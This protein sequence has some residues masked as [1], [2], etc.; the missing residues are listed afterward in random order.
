M[1]YFKINPNEV[2]LSTMRVSKCKKCGT[3]TA[4]CKA[5]ED[6]KWLSIDIDHSEMKFID[7][8]EVFEVSGMMLAHY[9]YCFPNGFRYKQDDEIIANIFNSGE[10][11]YRIIG[12]DKEAC[13]YYIKR[14]DSRNINEKAMMQLAFFIDKNAIPKDEVSEAL[15]T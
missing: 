15:Y 14:L 12:L 7:G 6:N 2:L 10:K 4:I 11:P 5:K 3:N 1:N 8:T 9:I 13:T